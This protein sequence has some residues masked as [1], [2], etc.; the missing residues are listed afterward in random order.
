MTITKKGLN[1]NEIPD[2]VDPT[3][4]TGQEKFDNFCSG[5]FGQ[6]LGTIYFLTGNSGA[7]KTTLMINLM[8]WYQDYTT[9]MYLRE[10]RASRIIKQTRGVLN[11]P[12]ALISDKTTIST[13]N[14]YMDYLN[15]IK[16]TVVMVDSMQCI[17]NEDYQNISFESACDDVR[18]RLTK[19]AQEN[20]AIVFLI[21][22]NTKE[23]EF[24]GKN[25]HMQM[26]DAHL[27]ME[28]DE[29]TQVRKMYF[30]KK[31]RN[32]KVGVP[33][34]YEI[35]DGKIVFFTEEE[36]YEK[37]NPNVTKVPFVDAVTKLLKLYES[38]GNK[39]PEFASE[40]SAIKKNL[41]I[42]NGNVPILVASD[43]I[44]VLNNLINKYNV[45]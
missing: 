11:N 10:M 23:G 36:Y 33:L 43:M 42:K 12:K 20:N 30:G 4:Q 31:N 22:H 26:V 39:N 6:V 9:S 1:F 16:P 28:Y 29:K 35:H 44:I 34:F 19:W 27:V 3:I 32:G 45:K 7:G 13:F 18:I 41:K 40:L 15:E 2:I 8:Q 38:A 17:A 14:E 37:L 5:D 25:T 21:G 24:A